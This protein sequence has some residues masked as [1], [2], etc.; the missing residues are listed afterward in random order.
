MATSCKEIPPELWERH[1]DTIL[2]LRFQEGL[3]LDSVKTTSRNVVQIMRDDHQFEATTAQYEAQL[4]RWKAAKYLKRQDWEM[5]LPLYTNLERQGLK[6]RVRLGDQIFEQKRIEKARRRY[7]SA[8]SRA[9]QQSSAQAPLWHIE[10]YQHGHYEEYSGHEAESGFAENLPPAAVGSED[11]YG[12]V[13]ELPMSSTLLPAEDDPIWHMNL[14]EANTPNSQLTIFHPRLCSPQ[15]DTEIFSQMTNHFIRQGVLSGS[16]FAHPDASVASSPRNVTYEFA[17]GLRVAQHEPQSVFPDMNTQ[18]M[19]RRTSRETFYPDFSTRFL[20]NYNEG[21]SFTNSIPPL[22]ACQ[23]EPRFILS[24]ENIGTMIQTVLQEPFGSICMDLEDAAVQ[25]LSQQLEALLRDSFFE[26]RCPENSSILSTTISMSEIHER[27][28]LSIANNFAGLEGVPCVII[29]GILKSSSQTTVDLLKYLQSG[30]LSVSKPLADNLFRAA[31]E[32]SDYDLVNIILKTTHGQANEIDV[33][34]IVCQLDNETFTALSLASYLHQPAIVSK[35]ID[36]GAKV[37]VPGDLI[38]RN[39]ALT[40]LYQEYCQDW[41][42]RSRCPKNAA[43]AAEIARLS[44]D[45]EPDAV[46]RLLQDDFFTTPCQL[47]EVL[48]QAVPSEHHHELFFSPKRGSQHGYERDIWRLGSIVKKLRPSIAAKIIKDRLAE[49]KA[50]NCARSCADKNN[51]DLNCLLTLSITESNFELAEYLLEHTRPTMGNLSAAI[52]GRQQNMVKS[53]LEQGAVTRG[54]AV[55]SKNM[56]LPYRACGDCQKPTTPLAEAIRSQDW[57]L[58]KHLEENG[59]LN[60]ISNPSL[61]DLQA[62]IIATVQEGNLPYLK[63]LLVL[64]SPRIETELQYALAKAIKLRHT[65]L[66]DSLIEYLAGD[67]NESLIFG[68]GILCAALEIHDKDLVHKIIKYLGTVTLKES[69]LEEAV[70]W[71]D[72]DILEYMIGLMPAIFQTRGSAIDLAIQ[73]GNIELV[74]LLLDWSDKP[75]GL[76][77]AIEVGSSEMTRLMLKY[78]ADPADDDVFRLALGDVNAPCLDILSETFALKYPHGKKG[79]GGRALIAAIEASDISTLDL[80]IGLKLDVNSVALR[81]DSGYTTALL[82]AIESCGKCDPVGNEMISRLLKAGARRGRGPLIKAIKLSKMQ[83]V[84]LLLQ[85]GFNVNQPALERLSRTPLQQACEA[86]NFEM[87]EYLVNQGAEVNDA[88]AVN[89]G[90][91]A[92]QLAAISGNVRIVIFL[93]DKGASIHADPALIHGRTALEGAAEHGRIT[94]LNILLEKGAGGYSIDALEKAKSYAEKQKQR[95]C[96][97]RL[98]QAL[99]RAGAGVRGTLHL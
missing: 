86:G 70:R 30:T 92:I 36:Y 94:V 21:S 51:K 78:G 38:L 75:C 79:F 18:T 45:S 53:M 11:M 15:P 77:K 29:L 5:L 25:T 4:K 61:P 82:Y 89:G 83:I 47:L 28:L 27:I 60:R 40:S 73:M 59:A 20:P 17:Q 34:G 37:L 67:E 19:L 81:L 24:D 58:K 2:R 64:V 56:S 48:I 72:K 69:T 98:K 54:E 95:G 57:R 12:D 13:E 43:K 66:A 87:A 93:L 6:P 88:P 90:G 46:V 80:L 31:I 84:K 99:F 96:E 26:G 32:A 63:Q 68:P 9:L 42:G 55:C 44:L 76:E 74:T 41:E 23:N 1:K 7:F 8:K 3:P 85:N 52:R 50:V 49:C 14:S 10:I 33:N 97:E 65:E 62:A 16:P 39:C 35:L 91:T 22:V 71:G